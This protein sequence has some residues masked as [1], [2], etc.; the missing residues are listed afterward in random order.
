MS[1][2]WRNSALILSAVVL[3]FSLMACGGGDG[4]SDALTYDGS[5]DPAVADSTTAAILAEFGMGAI[6]AGFPL[7]QMFVVPPP[8]LEPL[9]TPNIVI[10][11]FTTQVTQ[12][13]PEEAVWDGA[14]YGMGGAGTADMNG[15]MTL[16]LFNFISA[17]ADTWWV[18]R[19]ELDG[20]IVFD[21]FSVDEDEP[22][23]SGKVTV[24]SSTFRLSNYDIPFILSSGN[25]DDD[26]GFPVWEEAAMTFTDIDLEQGDES[27]ALGEGDWYL[28]NVPGFSSSL[29]INSMTVGYE[30]QTYKIENTNVMVTFEEEMVV[31]AL[32]PQEI[33]TETTY[34]EIG[35]T[36]GADNGAFYHPELGLIYFSGEITEEDPPGDIVGD[37][38]EFFDAEVEGDILFGVYF[39][40]DDSVNTYA[41]ATF[42]N[43]YMS[44]EKYSERG[45]VID[46]SFIQSDLAPLLLL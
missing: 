32:E 43:L 7:T 34:I 42:Y 3:M 20:S 13:V 5:T 45:Y 28:Q 29:D 30:G 19:I 35:G 37:Y 4:G 10:P 1:K 44:T 9:A 8:E 38:L 12:T 25:F 24:I 16:F 31:T 6:E 27:W 41:P 33:E 2:F 14:D 18:D 15:T 36:A 40:Y 11:A 26:P 39:G 46:G 17:N 21:G 22:T 23:L